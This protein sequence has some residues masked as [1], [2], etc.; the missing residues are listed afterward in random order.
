LAWPST[1]LSATSPFDIN[2]P[3]Y[4]TLPPLHCLLFLSKTALGLAYVFLNT[5][6]YT[7]AFTFI[8][9]IILLP[10]IRPIKRPT[11]FVGKN[12]FFS[13]N[14]IMK[15]L[16]HQCSSSTFLVLG[17]IKFLCM[18]LIFIVI[19]NKPITLFDKIKLFFSYKNKN[20]LS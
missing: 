17:W 14:F 8:L 4:I 15:P 5:M 19:F 6:I 11:F 3:Q 2:I 9:F 7:N 10:V 18:I 20:I 13:I 12:T 1:Y 16:C